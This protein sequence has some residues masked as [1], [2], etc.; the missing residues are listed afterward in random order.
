MQFSNVIGQGDVINQ[1]SKMIDQNRVPHALLFTEKEGFGA[2]T[3]VLAAIQYLFCKNKISGDSCGVCPSCV[4]ISKLSHP[5]FHF[6]F[7]TNISTLVGKK[8][9][10]DEVDTFYPLWRKIVEKNPYFAEQELYNALGL[11]NRLGTI[12]VLDANSIIRKLS[13]SS[14]EGGAKVMLIMFPERMNTET[15]NKLLKSLE[16]PMPDTYYF[17]ISHNPDKIITTIL[18]R[19]RRVELPP[20]DRDILRDSLQKRFDFS[21]ED[22]D[23]WAHC[24][25]GSYGG[26]VK[27]ISSDSER[28]STY[29]LFI[30]LLGG[31]INKDLVKMT[32][33]W[34]SLASWGKDSQREFCREGMQ[35]LRKLYVLSLG[36][37]EISYSSIKER[38][39]LNAFAKSIKTNFYEKGYNLLNS[40]TE[41][42]E[43]NVNPKFIFCDL[44]NRFYY[45]I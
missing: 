24:S 39:Q 9:K 22:A 2:L 42:I 11:E 28:S 37:E 27:L 8:D 5:D 16:E 40:A 45:N 34:E 43:S 25:A 41:H 36:L 38:A 18:S 14:Y 3:I 12:A 33:I 7:P 19:C 10:K 29:E 4:K 21:V 1:I 15:A 6:S 13:L 26:A 20:I 35:I 23:F 32:D 44:C 30:D 31:A 17:L